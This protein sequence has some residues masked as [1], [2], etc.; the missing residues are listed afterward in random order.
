MCWDDWQVRQIDPL[1]SLE[2]AKKTQKCICF[3]NKIEFTTSLFIFRYHPDMFHCSLCP[4]LPIKRD[5]QELLVEWRG[6]LW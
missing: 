6:I 5:H 2:M 1:L 4:Q 3:I